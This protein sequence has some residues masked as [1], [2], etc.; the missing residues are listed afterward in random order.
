MFGSSDDKKTPAAAGEKKGLFG[1]LRKKPQQEAE[2]TPPESSPTQ[3]EPVVDQVIATP[4]VEPSVASQPVPESIA[5]ADA[6][7]PQITVEPGAPSP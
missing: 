3:P 6:P 2:P 7:A 4:Q 5:Q 1:W